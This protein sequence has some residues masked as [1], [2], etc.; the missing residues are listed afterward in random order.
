[1]AVYLNLSF[2]FLYHCHDRLKIE[3]SEPIKVV[4]SFLGIYVFLNTI[5]LCN[6]KHS[7]NFFNSKFLYFRQKSLEL[8][9]IIKQLL[10]KEIC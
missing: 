9:R 8:M 5:I 7:R 6:Q 1:M 10:T 4:R 3:M 2:T